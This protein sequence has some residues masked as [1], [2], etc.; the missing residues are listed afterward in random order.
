M[1]SRLE[2]LAELIAAEHSSQGPIA[3]GFSGGADSTAL[4]L[5]A[6]MAGFDLEAW[7]IDHGWHPDSARLAE[8]LAARCRSW[9][10][11]FLCRR[12]PRTQGRNREAVARRLRYAAFA[13]LARERNRFRLWLAHHAD[14]QAETVALRLLMGAGPE[15]IAGMRKVRHWQG[16]CIERPLLGLRKK[17]LQAALRQAGI[18]WWEDPTNE[19]LSLRRNWV[20][21]RL[22]PAMAACGIDPVAL[23]LRW[24]RAAA[25][26]HEA[27]ASEVRAISLRRMGPQAVAV[28]WE[29]W[30]QASA[31]VRAALL[32]AMI[33]AL[34]GEGATPGRRHILLAERWTAQGGRGGLDLSRSRL[35]RCGKE[36]R[37]VARSSRFHDE[38]TIV[39]QTRKAAS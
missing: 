37:L 10:I 9:G 36:L 26:V 8:Q 33:R 4:L 30:Q 13:E 35:E 14:D 1:D 12:V 7:H 38:T 6:K 27:I 29:A 20:R 5:A 15:G 28:D 11:P 21:K 18:D 17:A 3:V 24:G 16:L 25:R 2:A 32:K 23:F 31:V 39:T 22:F 19:D 34:F